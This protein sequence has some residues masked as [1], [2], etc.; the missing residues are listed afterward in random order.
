MPTF[1][2]LDKDKT[3]LKIIESILVS[4][5][6]DPN[7][8]L[9]SDGER[10]LSS[11]DSINPSIIFISKS[12]EYLE[13]NNYMGQASV[14]VIR[15]GKEKDKEISSNYSFSL[16][17]PLKKYKLE[18]VVEL[19][20]IMCN[21]YKSVKS[22]IEHINKLVTMKEKSISKKYNN[23]TRNFKIHDLYNIK[24]V[25]SEIIKN[26]GFSIIV[27][28]LINDE[29]SEILSCENSPLSV[30]PSKLSYRKFLTEEVLDRFNEKSTLM[31][32]QESGEIE[33]KII[34][35]DKEFPVI[36]FFHIGSMDKNS[37]KIISFIIDSDSL[38]KARQIVE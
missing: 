1:I 32:S 4:I 38:I 28:D 23:L 13:L 11:I 37:I 33:Y 36:D 25:Y 10:L 19:L 30:L 21:T 3:N 8:Y 12:Y 17:K 6:H 2:I 9:F 15:E 5:Y 16:F 18:T 14:V 31:N 22:D 34:N 35:K 27:W 26:S 29:A 7:I 20:M 24:G